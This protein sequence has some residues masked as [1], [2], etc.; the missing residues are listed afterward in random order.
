MLDGSNVGCND[1][2]SVGLNVGAKV[3][4]EVG[5][6]VGDSDGRSDGRDV[7]G[8]E[9]SSVGTRDGAIVGGADGRNVGN[10]VGSNVGPAVGV[11]QS[12]PI[13][14]PMYKSNPTV[15][16][17]FKF[18]TRCGI[19][20]QRSLFERSKYAVNFFN[21]PNCDG[22]AGSSKPLLSNWFAGESSFSCR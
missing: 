9:G 11:T 20:P 19:A 1:G 12:I 10:P 4:V 22:I 21:A 16:V 6:V 7:G 14:F 5:R 15:I 3:G 8:P 17:L 2:V 18:R 13:L